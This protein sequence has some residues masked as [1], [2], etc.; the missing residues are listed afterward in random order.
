MQNRYL[1]SNNDGQSSILIFSKVAQLIIK[2]SIISNFTGKRWLKILCRSI[3]IVGFAGVFA[4]LLTDTSQPFYWWLL[5][6]SGIGL[7]ALEALSNFIWFV[8]LRGVATYIKIFLLGGVF[9]D[10]SNALYYMVM[11]ILLSGMC[12]HAPSNIGYFSLLHF[13]KVTS[14]NDSKG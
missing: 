5:I 14:L 12:S 3:H 10:E 8:Q 11:I 6:V 13:K 2:T 9:F 1:Q 4:S 7:L